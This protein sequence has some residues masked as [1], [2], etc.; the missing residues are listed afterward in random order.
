MAV[1]DSRFWMHKGIDFIAIVR[2][3]TKDIRA[4]RIKEGASTITQ[5][6]AKVVFLSPE[7]TIVRKLKEVT[8]ARKLERNLTK[9]EIL[10]YGQFCLAMLD[11]AIDALDLDMVVIQSGCQKALTAGTD[12][13]QKIT[14][15]HA[16]PAVFL[17]SPGGAGYEAGHGHIFQHLAVEMCSVVN[18]GN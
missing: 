11:K 7:R 13:T 10:E 12:Q 3:L 1:E 8:L 18:I 4:G 5:Q 17:F 16:F 15:Q 2:A 14:H 6:L 9:E